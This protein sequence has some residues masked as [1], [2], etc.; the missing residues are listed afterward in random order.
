MTQFGFVKIV[1]EVVEDANKE[2]YETRLPF[3]QALLRIANET[4]A[5]TEQTNGIIGRGEIP[6]R[7]LLDATGLRA[8]KIFSV[9][10][11]ISRNYTV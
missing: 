6:D 7:M 5:N 11:D 2:F 10:K 3:V 1:V 4:L 8:R 9:L